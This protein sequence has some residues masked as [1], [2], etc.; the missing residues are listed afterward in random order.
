MAGT[1]TAIGKYQVLERL[2]QGGMGA[3]FLAR[4]PVLDRLV[5][6]K[7]LSG[8]FDQEV[9]RER[10]A[11][12]ARAV[13]RLR[14]PNIVTIFD[15]ESG[16]LTG[17]PFIAMEYITGES[18][19]ELIRRRAPIP[20]F[21]KL[22][23]MEELCAGMAH[24]H[25]A[26]IVHR[27]IKPANIMVDAEGGLIK[28]LDFGIARSLETSATLATGVIGTPSYMSP[29]QA[30]GTQVD[31]R[32]DIFSV[33][34]VFYELLSYRLAYNGESG[35]AIIEKILHG[36]PPPLELVGPDIEP[37]IVELVARAT[38]RLPEARYQDLEAMRA[39]IKVLRER[40][41]KTGEEPTV[42]KAPH[43]GALDAG[44][45]YI[46]DHREQLEKRR[47]SQVKQHT[48][49][50]ERAFAGAEY[51]E[52]L[53]A[54]EQILLLDAGHAVALEMM[55][56]AR[57]ALEDRA[58][59]AFI[60]DARLSF[61]RADLTAA[62]QLLSEALALRGTIPLAIDLQRALQLAR[63]ERERVGER[64]AAARS[65]L[66][67]ARAN[68]TDGALESAARAAVEALAND[69][70]LDEARNIRDQALFAL[71]ERRR[72]GEFE[73]QVRQLVDRARR[74]FDEG[75]R[76]EALA[77]LTGFSPR[78]ELIT[79]AEFDLRREW[80]VAKQQ[81]REE[82]GRRQQEAAEQ[83]LQFQ[84]EQQARRL[85]AEL[86]LDHARRSIDGGQLDAAASTLHEAEALDPAVPGLQELGRVAEVTRLAATAR[87]QALEAKLA[88]ARQFLEE[89]C[90]DDA[91]RQ[92]DEALRIDD[93]LVE[94]RLLGA[95][96][97]GLLEEQ[98]RLQELE[99]RSEKAINRPDP[100][101]QLSQIPAAA[102][103]A[104]SAT[105]ATDERRAESGQRWKLDLNR[106]SVWLLGLSAVAPLMFVIVYGLTT[107]RVV[108]PSDS[109]VLV[110][111]PMEQRVVTSPTLG[112]RLVQPEPVDSTMA[113]PSVG[114]SGNGVD[115][116]PRRINEPSVP[117][118]IGG[119]PNV[120][121]GAVLNA[122]VVV[123]GDTVANIAR[124]ADS[125]ND[126]LAVDAK[127][128]S[129]S[130]VSRAE[131][132]RE[133]KIGSAGDEK[134]VVGAPD[135][136]SSA[137][138]AAAGSNLGVASAALDRRSVG[139][140]VERYRQA[141]NRKD[142]NSIKQVYP[143]ATPELTFR[144]NECRQVDL[145]FA[146]DIRVDLLSDGRAQ[147]ETTSVYSCT[148]NTRQPK[149]TEPPVTDTFRLEKRN[150]TWVIVDLLVSRGR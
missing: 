100:D 22:R 40:V 149:R 82:E 106:P 137:D 135:N 121:D 8:D 14:H 130:P 65:A 112:P 114:A 10:F 126:G 43:S 93:Q 74:E 83:Q 89:R 12:E 85:R 107:G 37:A 96:I 125:S 19:A 26:R 6:I 44:T 32:S 55:R 88:K 143:R 115:L 60:R 132:S 122:P 49:V 64:E 9:L 110:A 5:A 29:E 113:T 148:P 75:R 17:Q 90:F 59:D 23:M 128:G 124:T 105:K 116:I 111:R 41:Q 80:E 81:Q 117:P 127:A 92:I 129:A 69:A 4:D 20:L 78:H 79:L 48:R 25:R 134:S 84:I 21:R 31:H 7:V 18:W 3:V 70:T 1:L 11:R 138:V 91:L 123:A 131:V 87:Q 51:E 2:G 15:F 53:E 67:R 39:D 118:G 97:L 38:A 36:H 103:S 63:R 16:E 150:G 57:I 109:N 61:E 13:S 140:A 133:T 94:A 142:M 30:A 47:V 27:D 104:P 108:S 24:A 45:P 144:K 145:T 101:S 76:V 52:V 95:E 46:R 33:G 35:N 98:R 147:V 50:A 34:S 136:N 102:D 68:W 71:D 120:D 119:G 141:Y 62:E 42:V 73:I 28:I 99:R 54:C 56:K 66:E 86:L 58:V 146:P 139:E 72:Q 77:M